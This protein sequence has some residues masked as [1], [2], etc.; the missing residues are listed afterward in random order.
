MG[1]LQV[2]VQL[3]LSL[4]LHQHMSAYVQATCA[5]ASVNS[6]SDKVRDELGPLLSDGA[7]IVLPSDDAWDELT[8]R[9][10]APRVHPNY[11]AI[12]EVA[13]ESD[14]QNTVRHDPKRLCC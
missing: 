13:T 8:A 11:L 7:A 10:S 3:L 12:V 14:V 6:P 4:S 2:G 5:S 1:F 9:A